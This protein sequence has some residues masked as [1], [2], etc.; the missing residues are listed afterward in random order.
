MHTS[1]LLVALLGPGAAPASLTPKAPIWEK[2][3]SAALAASREHSRPVVIFV[4]KG[5]TGW[6][7]LSTEGK[8]GTQTQR[9]LAD[10]YVCFYADCST[11][12]GRRLAEALEVNQDHGLVVGTRDGAGMAFWHRGKMSQ[13][14]L[15]TT[16]Q[17]YADGPTIVQTETLERV[18]YRYVS[19]P[20]ASTGQV[21]ASQ[22]STYAVPAIYTPPLSYGSYGGFSGGFGGGFTSGSC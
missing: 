14:E 17:K 7:Q 11:A 5:P 13:E 12:A 16:L 22:G 19:Y 2:S 8:L 4:G 1:F 21:S 6:E 18:R 20:V 9:L 15:M 3:Y 10:H